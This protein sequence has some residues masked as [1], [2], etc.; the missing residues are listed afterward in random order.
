MVSLGSRVTASH[1]IGIFDANILEKRVMMI[2]TKR[3]RH[4]VFVKY[5]LIVPAAV[6]LFSVAVGAGAMAVA[7]A[8][9]TTP[10]SA[11]QEK[12]YGQVYKI[13]KDVSAP[14]LI[15]SVE[16]VYPEAASKQKGKF[17]GSCVV[18]MIVDS[19]GVPRDVHITRSLA[20]DFD[21]SAIKAVQQYR[22]NPALRAGQ[23]VAVSVNVEVNFKKY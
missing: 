11:D 21:A 3:Q 22:F 16:P 10:Q 1:A 2:N 17:D 7:V 4:S 5:G 23:P 9:Q 20:A 18:G 14:K 15:S 13:G 12:P 8:P 6:L 19:S